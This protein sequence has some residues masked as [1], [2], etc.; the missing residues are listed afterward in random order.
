[1]DLIT[2][3][4]S[5]KFP[6]GVPPNL[7]ISIAM[8]GYTE[9][10][11]R[12]IIEEDAETTERWIESLRRADY[13]EKST[14]VDVSLQDRTKE[15]ILSS[16]SKLDE[17]NNIKDGGALLWKMIKRELETDESDFKHRIY[18]LDSTVK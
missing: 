14:G 9:L 7:C 2:S 5:G 12:N 8:C 17:Y 18:V 11:A 3:M 10:E 13:F 1:M 4:Q 15:E 16:G 6:E